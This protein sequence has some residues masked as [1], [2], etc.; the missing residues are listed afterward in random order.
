MSRYITP[1]SE[2]DEKIMNTLSRIEGALIDLFVMVQ[3]VQAKN[4]QLETQLQQV[5]SGSTAPTEP[6]PEPAPE[7]PPIEPET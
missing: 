6:P 2:P 7:V 3:D 1:V 4:N 5:I